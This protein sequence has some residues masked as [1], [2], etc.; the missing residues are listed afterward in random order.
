MAQTSKSLRLRFE[1]LRVEQFLTED[2]RCISEPMRQ[3]VMDS[4]SRLRRDE[5]YRIVGRCDPVTSSDTVDPQS[6]LPLAT[7]FAKVVT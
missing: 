1:Q 6:E 5:V 2:A 3:V 7:T 4:M